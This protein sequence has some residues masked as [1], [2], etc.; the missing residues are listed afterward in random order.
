VW[1]PCKA[2]G[3]GLEFRVLPIGR[4]V[5]IRSALTEARAVITP[6]PKK[7]PRRMTP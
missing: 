4:N 6:K 3:D 7:M 5:R 1:R 2:V